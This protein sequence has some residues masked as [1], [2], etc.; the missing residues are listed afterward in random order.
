M[1]ASKGEKIFYVINE[2]FLVVVALVCLA[3]MVYILAVSLSSSSA[4]TAGKVFF[5]PVDFTLTGYEYLLKNQMFWKAMLNSVIRVSLGTVINVGCACLVAYP[6]SKPNE[7]FKLR[8]FYAWVFFIPMIVNG[9]LI[10]TYM[11][12]KDTN[13]ID[14]IW[15]LILPGAVPVFFIMVLLNFFRAIPSELEDAA[16]IDGAGQIR[17]LIQIF[18][19]LSKPALATLCVYAMLNHWNAWFD[20]T[21]YLNS[22]SKFPLLTYMQTVVV[23]YNPELLSPAELEQMSKLG[24]RNLEAAQIFASSLPIIMT[25]PFFQ[26]Y[27]TKGL[28]LGGVKG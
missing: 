24:G 20:G 19:P 14:S 21:I 5:W 10:P 2:V 23:N 8:T 12:V 15:S 1:K 25:Y 4:V 22:L 18:I 3:P 26:K 9:G 17:T 16:L 6:L 27:F 28:I 13:L 11:V 7:R